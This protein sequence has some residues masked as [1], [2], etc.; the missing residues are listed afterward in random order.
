V[1]SEARTPSRAAMTALREKSS[2][3]HCASERRPGLYRLLRI[4]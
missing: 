3:R 2:S 1:S 4:V